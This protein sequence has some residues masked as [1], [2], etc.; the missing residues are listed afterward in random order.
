MLL[1]FVGLVSRIGSG[2]ELFAS[3]TAILQTGEIF[4]FGKAKIAPLRELSG[5]F[6][7]LKS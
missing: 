1:L 6:S 7:I 5:V 2:R 3:Y 4:T